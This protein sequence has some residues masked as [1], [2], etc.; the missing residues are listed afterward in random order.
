[1][2]GFGIRVRVVTHDRVARLIT[3]VFAP[4]VLVAAQIVL[5]GWHAGGHDGVSRWWGLPGAAFAAAIP[6]GYVMRGV[7]RGRYPDHHIPD[8]EHR[9]LPLIVGAASLAAGL[10]VLIALG[11]PRDVIA[12]LAAGGAGVVIFGVIT[13]WWKVSIHAG[14]AAGTIAVLVAVFGPWA[15]TATPV[16]LVVA[17]ARVRLCALTV[18]LVT[19]GAIAGAAI[20]GTVFP[21]LR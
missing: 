10:A 21:A 4:A 7:R 13:Q 16:V 19:A 3:E 17:W 15:L 12:L 5:V 11:A 2:S 14:V 20:A 6:F 18:A 9:R 1:V 8:R